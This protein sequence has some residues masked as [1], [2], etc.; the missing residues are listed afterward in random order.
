MQRKLMS[1]KKTGAGYYYV[2]GS[3]HSEK[4]NYESAHVCITEQDCPAAVQQT[5][6]R[7]RSH[8]IFIMA[9]PFVKKARVILTLQ[10][11]YAKKALA[12]KVGKTYP[13]GPASVS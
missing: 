3:A 10:L 9:L 5:M 1:C 6:Y 13:Y 4:E 7:N 11:W 2:L 12:E 8:V